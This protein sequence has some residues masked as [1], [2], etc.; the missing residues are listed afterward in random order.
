MLGTKAGPNTIAEALV[1]GIPIVLTHA[2]PAQ[3]SPNVD[4]I[5]DEGA[6]VWAPGPHDCAKA[7]SDILTDGEL[8]AKIRKNAVRLAR[9]D[10]AKKAAD[11]LI[12]IAEERCIQ[13]STDERKAPGR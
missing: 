1:L 11:L 3:E 7:I 10:A 6:G 12:R 5:V 2:I 8:A 13:Q 4:W 9:P